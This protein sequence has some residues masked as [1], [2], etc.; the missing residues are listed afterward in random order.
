MDER[1]K[2]RKKG[3]ERGEKLKG[4]KKMNAFLWHNPAVINVN[5]HMPFLC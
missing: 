5:S 1:L 3:K 2:E 4:E